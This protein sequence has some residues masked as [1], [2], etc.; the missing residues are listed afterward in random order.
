MTDQEKIEFLQNAIN[1]LF[2]QKSG[3]VLT[4]N[5]NLVD[6][7]L[8]SLDI[9]ELQMYYEE[10]TNFEIS[11]ESRIITVADLMALMK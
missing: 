4:P 2:K 11:V 5:S 7:G 10:K 6:F 3:K 1:T 9:V 8:D